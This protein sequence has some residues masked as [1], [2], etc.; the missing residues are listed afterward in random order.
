MS[1]KGFVA[2]IKPALSRAGL[3]ITG[4]FQNALNISRDA[5]SKSWNVLSKIRTPVLPERERRPVEKPPVEGEEDLTQRKLP[6]VKQ[7]SIFLLIYRWL[8]LG[9]VLL[10]LAQIRPHTAIRVPL[11]YAYL[12]FVLVLLYN[13]ALT[14]FYIRTYRKDFSHALLIA[15]DCLIAGL[16]LYSTGGWR[17]PYYLYSFSPILTAALFFKV[18]GGL[19]SASA[20]SLFYVL[21]LHFNDYTIQKIIEMRVLDDYLA[22]IFSYFLIAGFFVYP[23]MLLD[24][25]E[26]TATRLMGTRDKLAETNIRYDLVNKRLLVLQEIGRTLQ[27]TLDLDEVLGIV[28][29]GITTGLGFDRATLGLVNERERVLDGWISSSVHSEDQGA[30]GEELRGLQIPISEEGGIPARSVIEKKPFSITEVTADSKAGSLIAEFRPSPFAVVPLIFEGQ[31]LGVIEVDNTYSKKPISDDDMLVLTA[32]ASQVAIAINHAHLYKQLQKQVET[33]SS[34]HE[35]AGVISSK[36]EIEE[37]LN[38]VVDQAKSITG[39]GKAVLCLVEGRRA[40]FKL[41]KAT[42][43]VRGSRG[44][45]PETWWKKPME[46]LAREVMKTLELQIVPYQILVEPSGVPERE[47]LLCAPV[48]VKNRCIGIL[49]AINSYENPFTDSDIV[50]LIILSRLAAVAIENARLVAKAQ[51]LVVAVERSRIATEMHDG[52]AQSLF[53]VVLNLQACIQQLVADPRGTKERL[54]QLQELASRD[55]KEVRQYIYDLQPSA[56]KELGLV[57]ALKKHVQEAAGMSALD[58]DFSVI[59]S[60][61][62]LPPAVEGSLYRM[63]QEALGN[64]IKYAGAK[65]IAVKLSF[66]KGKVALSVEDNGKGFDVKRV[67]AAVRSEGKFGLMSMRE[68]VEKLDGEFGIESQLGK[69]TKIRAT[70]PTL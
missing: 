9:L 61:R 26:R 13:L 35:V 30:V 21:A 10:L 29:K 49:S 53:S 46:N 41:S 62:P 44:E 67:L 31:A 8:T 48:V 14:R 34:L 37:V 17:S 32:L 11:S 19:L 66:R 24:H 47:W 64:A 63:A 20:L 16:L 6:G 4:V 56:L 60:R 7:I 38:S 25:L 12:F 40:R 5:L 51:R 54:I 59:G 69:G 68:R 52:L 57:G 33:L 42:M 39:T 58:I 28:L 15:V 55:L 43:V 27:S 50:T 70:V 65:S 1:R 45:H 3:K 2:F 22:N 18:R 23:I 36:L